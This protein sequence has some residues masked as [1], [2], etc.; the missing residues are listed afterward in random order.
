[1]FILIHCLLQKQLEHPNN[2]IINNWHLLGTLIV[3][4]NANLTQ[5]C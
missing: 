1:M 2:N 5:V 3:I 4:E